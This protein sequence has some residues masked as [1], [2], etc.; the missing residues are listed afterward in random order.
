VHHA[1][2]EGQVYEA[3]RQRRQGRSG[4]QKAP[5]KRRSVH[6]NIYGVLLLVAK[7][8]YF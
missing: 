4:R 6:L 2:E 1:H 5:V 7:S 8:F 3:R